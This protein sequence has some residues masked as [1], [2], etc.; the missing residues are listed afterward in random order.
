MTN[1]EQKTIIREKYAEIATAPKQ[2]SCCCSSPAKSTEITDF[3]EKYDHLEGYEAEA[4]LSLGCGL[5]TELAK[6]Q[7]GDTVLDLGSGAGIDCF[8]A[9]AETGETGKVIGVDFTPE[10]V[11]RAREN[12]QKR[13]FS[14]VEFHEGEIENLPLEPDSVDVV[15]SN[16]VMN[17]VPDKKRAFAETYRVM[18]S[19]GHFSIS[20]MVTRSELPE[21]LRKDA[22]QFAGCVATTID[23][24]T[25]LEFVR[26]AGF[27]NISIQRS[28]KLQLPQ[29]MLEKYFDAEQVIDF[30]RED[31]GLFS[32]S[33]YAEK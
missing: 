15:V 3:S 28:R 6:I 1:E 12:A 7:K 33:L 21:G 2:T 27:R 25:Y 16:C 5:P 32:V 20:D 17:L 9:R 11:A 4:N 18:R 23:L 30:Q 31:R 26:Q 24:D 19:G 10:M 14:N 13:G 22:S 29:E 8:V